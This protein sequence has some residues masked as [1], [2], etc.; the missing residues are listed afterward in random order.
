MR[1]EPVVQ[2]RRMAALVCT[3]ALAAVATIPS[4][5]TARAA[6]DT[7]AY[8]LAAELTSDQFTI[9]DVDESGLVGSP[10]GHVTFLR[11]EGALRFWAPINGGTVELATTDF[12]DL[13]AMTDPATEVLAPS[14]GTGFDSEYAGGSKVLRLGDG[15]LAMLYHGEHHPC[16]GDKA[17]VTIGLA[18]SNDNGATWDRQGAIV[19]APAWTF[20]SCADRT[21]Y[22]AGSFSAVVSPDRQYVYMYFNQWVP[23]ESGITRVARAAISSGLGPGTWKKYFRGAWNEPGLGGRAD[24]VLPVPLDARD[25][26]WQSVAIPSVSWNPT[27]RMWLAVYVTVTGFWYSSSVDGVHWLAPEQLIDG[28]VLWAPESLVDHQQYIYYPS[29]IDTAADEDGR[30]ATNGLLIYAQGGWTSAHH[31]VGRTVRISREAIPPTST[32]APPTSAAP[33]TAGE[34][35]P[36]TGTNSTLWVSALVMMSVGIIC[37]LAARSR[38][39]ARRTV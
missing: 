37:A 28:V 11:E 22:G 33:T 39:Q 23:H 34:M 1:G 13:H 19:T 9:L 21:F 10:D 38:A 5:S 4:A 15:R 18:T 17:E 27:Y 12:L 16:S 14:G 6:A 25:Q 36:T 7:T 8:R 35:L 30:T 26:Q 20:A 3:T 29:L 32:T 24:D 2:R 31:M